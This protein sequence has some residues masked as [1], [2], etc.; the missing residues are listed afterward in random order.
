[1]KLPSITAILILLTLAIA[2]GIAIESTISVEISYYLIPSLATITIFAVFSI[3]L[4]GRV[5]DNLFGEIGF[6][7]LGLAVVYTILPASAFIFGSLNE[8]NNLALL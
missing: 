7:Y 5:G 6:L 3:I 4:K 2:I 8:D 1:M